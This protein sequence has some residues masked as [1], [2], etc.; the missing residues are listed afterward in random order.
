MYTVLLYM[1][2]CFQAKQLELDSE[3]GKLFIIR[4]VISVDFRP[5]LPNVQFLFPSLN[6]T[7]WFEKSLSQKFRPQNSLQV[8]KILVY[9]IEI[10]LKNKT[11]IYI[12]NVFSHIFHLN[13]EKNLPSS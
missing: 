6:R 11:L 9:F 2:E 1:T 12:T 7:F 4:Q 5:I 8:A 10:S 13:F 3:I